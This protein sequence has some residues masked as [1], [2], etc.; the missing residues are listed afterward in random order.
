MA[1]RLFRLISFVLLI[2]VFFASCGVK[3]HLKQDEYLVNKYSLKIENKPEKFDASDVKTLFRPRPNKKIFGI[4]AGLSFY[5]KEQKNPTKF[6]KWLYKNFGEEP[7]LFDED[8]EDQISVKIEKYLDNIGYFN[9]T[10]SE[11]TTFKNKKAHLTYTVIL[12]QPYLISSISYDIPDSVLRNYFNLIKDKTL[13]KSGEIYNAYVM[14]DERDRINEYLRNNGYYFFNRNYIQFV[15]DSSYRNHSMKVVMK[16]TNVKEPDPENP[17][18]LNEKPHTRYYIKKVTVIPDLIPNAP[19]NYDTAIHT[20]ERVKEKTEFAYTFLFNQKRR[21]KANA[22]N[23]TLFVEPG[24]PY[25]AQDVQNTYRRLFNFRVIRTATINFDT[26]GG[27]WNKEHTYRYMN[28]RVQVQLAKMNSFQV[29]AEGTNSS[30][31]LGLRG[32]IIYSNKNIFKQGEL[33]SIRLNGGFEAQTV[34]S[35]TETGSQSEGIFNT[36]ELG[37]SGSI[38]FPRFLFL[39]RLERF[40]Q[41]FTPNTIISFGYNYQRRPNYTRN[42]TNLDISY[43]WQQSKQIEHIITPLN[44]NFVQINPTP[45][46]DSI[47]ENETNQ[48]LKEQYSDHLIFGIKYSFIFNNQNLNFL[49]H[50]NYIRINLETAGNVLDLYNSLANSSKTAEGYYEVFGVRYSQ[51]FRINSDYRHFYYL[52]KEK[53]KSLAFRLLLGL[54]VPYG[55]SKEIPYE[56]GFYGGGANDMRGWVFRALG[57]GEYSGPDGYERVGD[58]QIETNL[59]Y[60]FPLYEWFKG[61]FFVDVGNI[62]TYNYTEVFPGGQ[63]QWDNFYQQFAVDVGAG[64][65]LDLSFFIFRLDMAIPIVNPAFPLGERN[66][67]PYL[68]W[69]QFVGNFGIG[70][71]F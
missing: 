55:N 67:I 71:P 47:I 53:N 21:L 36:Y 54:A 31:D 11:K 30:G 48:R 50:F 41:K 7:V 18:I 49:Q 6:N 51:Y 63:F 61:A 40:D 15:V 62:W 38:F 20:I 69:H 65:R 23:S 52:G 2:M 59:E 14:D 46:F 19:P 12:G 8:Q 42:L 25:S 28:S 70:Y 58:I 45:E 35:S 34:Y 24:T 22:F 29:E 17:E 9:S 64:L 33:L 68:Q 43:S 60:R 1:I 4:R 5:F 57:P 3:K 16:I 13:I 66:R 37:A 26:T 27:G 56:K 39:L 44:F 10:I 32:G